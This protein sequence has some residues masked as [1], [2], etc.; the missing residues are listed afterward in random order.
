MEMRNY[1]GRMED[2]CQMRVRARTEAHVTAE[3]DLLIAREI[4]PPAA[5]TERSVS[6]GG[7]LREFGGYRSSQD[8]HWT[9]AVTKDT[10]RSRR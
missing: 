7:R 2:G 8:C 1:T 9:Q 5:V 6:G 10:L 4:A 3:L